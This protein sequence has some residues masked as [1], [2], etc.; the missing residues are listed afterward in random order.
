MIRSHPIPTA[1]GLMLTV[2]IVFLVASPSRAGDSINYNRD[3]RPVLSNNC[4]QCHGP[5]AENRETELRLDE[6]DSALVKLESGGQ[7]V[8]PGNVDASLLIERITSD[9]ESMRMPPPESGKV[10]SPKQIENFKRWIA[11]GAQWQGHWAFTPPKRPDVPPVQHENWT[12]NPIDRFILARLEAEGLQPMPEADRQTLIRRV[13][14]DLTGLPPTPEEI[15]AFLLDNSAEAYE[16]LV[17]RLLESSRYGE[18]QARYWLDAARYG[19]T[20]GLHLDNYRSIWPYRDWVIAALNNNMP[21]DQFTVEQLAGDLL[22]H[23]TRDQLVATG[24]NRCNVTTSEGGSID[25]EYLVRYAVDRAKTTSTVWMG[26]TVGCAVCHDHKFD[27]I[28]QKEFYQL[29]AYF[30]SLTEKAM[31]GNASNPPPVI[32]VPSEEQTRQL[33]QLDDQIASLTAR[34][35]GPLPQVDEAQAAWE[36][37]QSGQFRDRWHV[38]SPSEFTSREGATLRKLDDDSILAEGENPAEDVYE[39]V[40]STDLKRITAIRLQALTD[41]ALPHGGPGRAE[42]ANFVLSEF[43]VEAVSTGNPS[44]VRSVKFA[45]ATADFSQQ[46]GGDFRIEKAIDGIVDNTN[47]WAVAGFQ[48]RENRTAVFVPAEPIGFDGGTTLRFRLRFESQFAQHAI[49]RLRLSVSTDPSLMPLAQS[50]WS[51]IGPFTAADGKAAFSTEFGPEQKLD[52]AASYQNDQL[53]WTLHDDFQDGKAHELKGENAATYLYRTITV[54]AARK[55]AVSLGSDDAVK[56]WLNGNLVLDKYVLRAVAADQDRISLDLSAGEN[57]LLIKV[58]NNAGGYAF[59]YKP[60]TD[61]EDETLTDLEPILVV[62][63]ENRT[64]AQQKQLR[65]AYRRKYSPQWN[66]LKKELVTLEARKKQLE[67]KIPTTMVMQDMPKR[68]QAYVL[69]RGQYD[70]PSD[71]VEPGVPAVLPPLPKDAP[72]NRLALARWLVDGNHPLTARVTVN[73]FWRQFFGTGIVKTAEDF[74]SQGEWPSHPKLLDWL[75]VE[76]TE[77][78]WDIKHMMKLIATSA[79]YRQSADVTPDRHRRDPENRLLSR[80]PR[81]RMDA[82]MIRDTALAVSGLLVEQVGG[83]SVKPYQPLGL[84]KTVGYT[85]SNTANFVKDSG[86]KLYR[87]SLYTFWKRTSPPPTMRTFDA[88]SRES[89]TVR[90]PRTNTPLQAL[91]LLNDIQFVE[92]ARHFAHRIMTEGGD[93]VDSRIAF[94][95]RLATGRRPNAEE[96]RILRE[97]LQGHLDDYRQHPKAALELLG[98]G[99]SPRDESLDAVEHAAWAMVAN[100]LLNLDETI[101]KG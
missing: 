47:G 31:D 84:W 3:I 26:L 95:F 61:G 62:S 86:G 28:T 80:G 85:S 48:R 87:R 20:H 97:T 57:R 78:G 82:E 46:S 43:E 92:A 88:P 83:P 19:D 21:F 50:P 14:L 12:R 18:H 45:H 41:E 32:K 11:E 39:V 7:A 74:G 59:Y 54:P 93:D 55:M 38:L 72:E 99:D 64:A 13:T 56:V 91:V 37:E 8:V 2:C 16:K 58:V 51:A 40:V 79:T 4:Y 69:I 81:F 66:A 10:L 98:V 52:L 1:W 77:S 68:R 53:R 34:L 73:R 63:P 96:V 23:P 44:E 36:A 29:Y 90:R 42:N 67:A 25:A 100:L 89:C 75:A 49:G 6:K 27:P 71:K 70:Q 24:F 35:D 101:T 30:Y 94:G 9:D 33:A 65:D 60:L 76:F 17:D 5:D 22:P 15:D